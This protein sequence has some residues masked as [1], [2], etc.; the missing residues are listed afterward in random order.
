MFVS[1]IDNKKIF[2]GKNG[3]GE[4]WGEKN[5]VSEKKVLMHIFDTTGGSLWGSG[6]RGGGEHAPEMVKGWGLGLGWA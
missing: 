2:F 3:F 6:V 5:Q 1:K 4:G